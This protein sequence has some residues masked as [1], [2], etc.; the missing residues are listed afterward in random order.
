MAGV[1]NNNRKKLIL[2]ALATVLLIS[3]FIG[4]VVGVKSR[5]SGSHNSNVQSI[6]D[7][8]AHEIV[9]SSCS[10][11]FYPELCYST[12]AS[13][14]EVSTKVKTQKDAIELAVSMTTLAMICNMTNTDIANEN[15]LNGRNLKEEKHD[16]E[17]PHWMS[18]KDRKLLQS[19]TVIPNVVVAADGS[20][21]HKTVAAAVEA[22]PKKSKTRY[23]IRIKAGVYRENVEVPKGKTNIMFIGDGRK[24]TIITASR[25]VKGTGHTTFESATRVK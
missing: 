22:A 14:P 25:S 11:T 18:V 20:G 6:T 7:S 15:K 9:K 10:A 24:N 13:H 17:W 4:I 21:D 3:A 16:T 23:V 1:S 5:N 2:G 19:G 8:E 12:I